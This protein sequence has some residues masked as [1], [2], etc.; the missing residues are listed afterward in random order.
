MIY[1]SKKVVYALKMFLVKNKDTNLKISR[2]SKV[3]KW[4]RKF[5]TVILAENRLNAKD[6]KTEL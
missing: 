6:L 5:K 4:P 2:V 3:E 1:L